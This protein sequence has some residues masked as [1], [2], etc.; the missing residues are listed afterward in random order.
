MLY[1]AA[2][3]RWRYPNLKTVGR[4]ILSAVLLAVGGL[5]MLLAKSAPDAIFSFYTQ[6]SRAALGAI[7]S[8]T[9]WVPFALWEALLVIL[10]LWALYTLVRDIANKRFLRWLSGLFLGVSALAFAFVALWGLNHYDRGVGEKLGLSVREYSVQEL[11]DATAFYARE[12]NRLAPEL[13]RDGEGVAQ[14]DD[15]S[16]LAKR[17]ADG[18][19]A[20][21][22][23]YA[24]FAGDTANIKKLAA[25][26]LYSRFGTTGIYVC[27]TAEAGVNPDTYV[28]WL[29]FTM[30]HEQAHGKGVAAEDE[31][32]F[33][34]FLACMENDDVQFRY[35]GALAAFVYCSN[36]LTKADSAAAGEI[37]A[38]LD[39]GALSD[40]RA[41]NQHYAQYEGKVQDAAQ[42]VNDAYLKAFSEEAGVQSYGAVA[43]LLI[44]W[45]QERT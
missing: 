5:L 23:Q 3:L 24:L 7:G 41:A 4:V 8:V 2:D 35:S 26:P 10:I 16:A 34:A 40:I 22:G 39:P 37:W 28:A 43:D 1:F 32:N 42:K 11:T 19:T 36:A 12:L 21:G 45:Y 30:C 15:F 18:Y 17:A 33:C 14:F 31:A 25:W 29:P 27:L 9:G 6:F 38:Q 44:A 20:L 13:T